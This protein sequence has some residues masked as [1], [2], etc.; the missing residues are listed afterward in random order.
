MKHVEVQ[1]QIDRFAVGSLPKWP[2]MLVTG[3]PVTID[4]AK[5][6]IFATDRFLVD[7]YEHSGG[8]NREFNANYRKLAGLDT[9]AVK[10]PWGYNAVDWHKA[11]RV[12][13]V[14]GVITNEYVTNDWA[15]SCFIGGPHGWCHPD[16]KIEYKDNVGKW[17]SIQDVYHEWEE[18]AQKFPFLD[19]TVTLMGGESCEEETSA[20]INFRVIDGKVT[21]EPPDSSMHDVQ[22]SEYWGYGLS[23]QG[24]P[25]SWIHEFA[26][27]VK[28]AVDFV[29]VNG[30]VK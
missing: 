21:I 22:I 24:L 26:F 11:D 14:L 20:V 23:E 27:R 19:L 25:N 1:E 30:G 6:I 8:N 7:P 17:P 15:S 13:K 4:Q 10:E 29:N 2:Q 5:D 18:I 12:R 3:N 28:S 9:L 16:G